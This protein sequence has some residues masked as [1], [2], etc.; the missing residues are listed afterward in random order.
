MTFVMT[1]N[2]NLPTNWFFSFQF[3][4]ISVL[5]TALDAPGEAD[6]MLLVS[7]SRPEFGEQ[8][9]AGSHKW[10]LNQFTKPRNEAKC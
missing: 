2:K 3:P 4:V 8:G 6:L 7:P 9:L 10:S 1:P 5:I